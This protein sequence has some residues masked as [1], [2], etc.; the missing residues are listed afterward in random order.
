MYIIYNVYIEYIRTPLFV[1]NSAYDT[2]QLPNILG[3]TCLPPNCN[4]AEYAE[5]EN[6]QLDFLS[7]INHFTNIPTHG[8]K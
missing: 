6:F 8:I 2:W 4:A 3:L 7:T 5:F 1:Y